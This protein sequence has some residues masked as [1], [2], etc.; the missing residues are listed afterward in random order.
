[1]ANTFSLLHLYENAI[2][3]LE[4]PG[5]DDSFTARKGEATVD[6]IIKEAFF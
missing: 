2:N 3:E 1:M 6:E 4:K 5:L